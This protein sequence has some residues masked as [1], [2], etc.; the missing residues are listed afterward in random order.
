MAGH[1]HANVHTEDPSD[2]LQKQASRSRLG[3][4]FFALYLTAYAAFVLCNTFQPQAMEE[5]GPSGIQWSVASGM[6][7]ILLAVLLSV[8]YGYLCRSGRK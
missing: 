1:H 6:G 5:P 8:V 3:L 7:L 4:I 2:S